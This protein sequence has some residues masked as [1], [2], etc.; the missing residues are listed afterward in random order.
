MTY[1]AWNA[2]GQGGRMQN[3]QTVRVSDSLSLQDLGYAYDANG[4]ILSISDS[5]AGPQTQGF[6][7]DSLDRLTSASATGGTDG[8]YNE[9]YTYNPAT[10]SLQTKAGVTLNYNDPDHAHAVS[11]T[12]DGNSYAY[13]AN[14]NQVTRSISGVGTYT[15]TYNAENQMTA[16]S[17]PNGLNATFI[18]DGD[19]RRV[20]SV[21]GSTTTWFV[22]NMYEV[23]D[24][25][26]TKYYYAG[27]QRIA[28]RSGSGG[29]VSYLLG[30]HL[31]STSITTDAAGLVSSEQR[32]TAWGE[33]RY[34]SGSA[35]IKYTYTGQYSNIADFGL[36]F[37]N[38]LL[39]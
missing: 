25:V 33:V 19:G 7:Y 12:S 15:L 10:G 32:Y 5:L 13:D 4:N 14:G 6:E 11:S 20:K 8:L 3:M 39:V 36:L 30:D 38:A 1:F 24:G 23:T 16:V 2:A 21:I 35:G 18:Y 29:V 37:Y 28:T 26:V 22:G 34:S 9:G 31:G 17:G 27:G